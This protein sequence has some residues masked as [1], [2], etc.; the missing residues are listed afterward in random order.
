MS[1][2]KRENYGAF[3]RLTRVPWGRRLESGLT[4]AA[5]AARVALVHLFGGAGR[6]CAV[7]PVRLRFHLL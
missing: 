7:G 5:T 1:T 4:L 2:V 6:S 3:L